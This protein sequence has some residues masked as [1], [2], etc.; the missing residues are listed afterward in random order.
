MAIQPQRNRNESCEV[1]FLSMP[2]GETVD[3]ADMANARDRRYRTQQA[4]LAKHHAPV[5]SFTMNIAGPVKATPLIRRGFALGLSRLRFRLANLHARILQEAHYTDKT[6]FECILCVDANAAAL[7]EIVVRIEEDEP[8]GRL[9]DMDVMDGGGEKLERQTPRKCLLCGG[10]A[11]VC[12]RSR[13]H[14][15]RSLFIE[16]ERIL[17]AYFTDKTAEDIVAS[18]VRALLYELL[19]TPKP[20]LVDRA[21]CGAHSDMDTFTFA[22][23]IS[24]LHPYFARCARKGLAEAEADR[25]F[26][27]L[28]EP[29][30]EAERAMLAAT[31]G[32]NTHK[33]AI[34][35]LGIL[36]AAAGAL[37]AKGQAAT[38]E[39]LSAACK[40]ITGDTLFAEMNCLQK[41]S[42]ATAGEKMLL[43]TG[44]TGARGEAMRGY[45]TALSGVAVLEAALSRGQSLNDSGVEAF[46]AILAAAEDSNFFKRA[47]WERWMEWKAQIQAM[48]GGAVENAAKM[49]TAFIQENISPGGSA[50]LLAVAFFLHFSRQLDPVPARME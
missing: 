5:I 39:A 49:D 15:A 8:I 38:P 40:A 18:A 26:A 2:Y 6:G 43:E 22:A 33:G 25:L 32:V 29:G 14:D 21:N 13:T 9:F 30:L 1:Y 10:D 4:M 45:P 47:S 24:V 23:S 17:H 42:V 27:Q 48:R 3:A 44:M 20:G 46:M 31:G 37:L 34:F 50:D 12:G 28:R 11:A 41:E 36:S 7:K 16:A 19:T 35:A